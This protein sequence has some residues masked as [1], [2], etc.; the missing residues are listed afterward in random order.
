MPSLEMIEQHPTNTSGDFYFGASYYPEQLEATELETDARLMRD[1]GFNVVRMGEFAWSRMEP[2]DGCFDFSWLEH[3]V[4]TLARYGIR[5]LLCTP[6]AAPPKWLTD[7]HPEICQT[8][9]DGQRREFGK[10]R[11]YC[12]NSVEYHRYTRRIVTALAETFKAN[13]NV[14]GYQ[15]D[16]EFMAEQPH[17]YCETC[18]GRFQERLRGKFVTIE[19]LNRRWGM[20]FWSQTYRRFSEVV[21][22]K[23]D[24]NPTSIQELYHFFSDS[25]L[26]YAR[27]QAESIRMI[28][29][30]KII[31]HNICSS[32]FLYHLDLH[33][34]A[35]CLDVV[36]VDNYPM[37]WT[38]EN[39][40]G[41]SEDQVYHPAMASLALSMMRGLQGSP[42]WVTEA[43]TGRT[44]R[45]RRQLPGPGLMHVWTHQEIAH[46]AKAVIWFHWRQF[47]A[48]IEHL[49]HA[50]LECD[51]KPRRRYFEIQKTVRE[52]QSLDQFLAGSCPR[53][54]VALLRD[55]HCDWALADGHTHPDFRYQ[56]HLYLYYRALFENHIGADVI[57]P[58]ND[59]AGY[60]LVIAPSLLL[61]NESRSKHLRTY[62]ELGGTLILTV[63]SGLRNDDNALHRETLPAFMHE[64][65]GIEIEEQHALSGTNT[66]GIAPLAGDWAESRYE[67]ELL[68][69]VI[70]PTGALPLFA[71]TDLWFAGTPAI[72]VNQWGK[73]RVYYVATVPPPELVREW[74]A[75]ILPECGI[76]PKVMNSSSPMVESVV[77]TGPEG[78]NLHL[79]N[80][81][82]ERQT[83]KL[84]GD[85]RNLLDSRVGG[86]DTVELEPFS[87]V[88]LQQMPSTPE[89]FYA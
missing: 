3:A 7:K 47:S 87:A 15:L 42:F 30:D 54:E 88:V 55:Y 2:D 60:K 70:K 69:E 48:G 45:P 11:H 12:V 41:N 27:L 25:F 82:A 18:A 84:R 81:S 61:M 71:Y 78:E 53:P 24:H 23:V 80:F 13:S 21:L 52:I 66:T 6:T 37:A 72:T 51:G 10:R 49:M 19:E 31:T 50:V 56:R 77:S 9:S 17:C 1:A 46:G 28:S 43:Q 33:Q 29:P 44:F 75:G 38:L 34:L 4:E 68:F 74:I 58:E 39:E 76:V 35:S 20:A 89:N 79:I 16:N 57:H 86:S 73:G 65:C 22:P 62:V 85:Y 40:Y 32:G 26:N 63:Q 67:C 59:L 36:S 83:L 14:V 64:W 5:S 8:L